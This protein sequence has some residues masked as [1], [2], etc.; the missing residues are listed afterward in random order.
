MQ[1]SSYKFTV[2]ES[3]LKDIV[4]M[5][6]ITL[7]RPSN[8]DHNDIL[9]PLMNFLLDELIVNMPIIWPIHPR[10]EKQM[11]YPAASSGI[12]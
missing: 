3:I 1:L 12:S 8:V 6:H 7:H 9:E 11:N 10:A 2:K 5:I 4:Y